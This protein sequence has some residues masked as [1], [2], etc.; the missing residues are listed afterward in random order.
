MYIDSDDDY[1]YRQR[2]R[3]PPSESFSISSRLEREE[4]NHKKRA[5]SPTPRS[6]GNDAM[7]R[8]LHQISLIIKTPRSSFQNSAQVKFNLE[9]EMKKI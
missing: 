7:S 3:T 1:S 5:K 8:A 2:S 9:L 6:M 4:R